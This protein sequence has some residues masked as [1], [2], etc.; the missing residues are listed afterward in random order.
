MP[1]LIG[2]RYIISLN[3]LKPRKDGT[4]R[5]PPESGLHHRSSGP[6]PRHKCLP[7]HSR[8]SPDAALP[9]LACENPRWG[10]GRR[11]AGLHFGS[12]AG[13]QTGKD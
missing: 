12:Q 11:P 1:T 13:H 3:A 6:S 9:K 10:P 8:I 7:G 4:S 5:G 2:I